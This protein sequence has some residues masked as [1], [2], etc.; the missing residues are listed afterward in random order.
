MTQNEEFSLWKHLSGTNRTLSMSP[1]SGCAEC[2][3]LPENKHVPTE[4]KLFSNMAN[5]LC[6]FKQAVHHYDDKMH[7]QKR[8]H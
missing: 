2:I 3:K 1:C 5:I 4:V 8:L 7:Q 6:L